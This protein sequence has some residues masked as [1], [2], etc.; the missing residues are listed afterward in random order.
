M[1]YD[2][3]V[4]QMTEVLGAGISKGKGGLEGQMVADSNTQVSEYPEGLKKALA[5]KHGGLLKRMVKGKGE[6]FAKT[7]LNAEEKKVNEKRENTQIYRS[8]MTQTGGKR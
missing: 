5:T 1:G 2:E 8:K 7:R 4:T 3:Q 6:T